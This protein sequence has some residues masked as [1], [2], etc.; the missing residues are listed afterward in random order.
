VTER[1]EAGPTR[2]QQL[3]AR[4]ER[5]LQETPHERATTRFSPY[6]IDS[7]PDP[8]GQLMRAAGSGGAEGIAAALD[9]FDRLAEQGDAG[10]PRHALLA[11]LIHHPDVAGLGLRIPSLEARSPWKVLPSEGGED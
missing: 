8:A 3:Q 10:R 7:G 4:I 11:F 6:L 9:A 1:D 2:R 5:A